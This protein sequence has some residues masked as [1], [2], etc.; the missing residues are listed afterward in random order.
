M[1]SSRTQGKYAFKD[2][3]QGRNKFKS[4]IPQFKGN[5]DVDEFKTQFL[6][7]S[8][9]EFLTDSDFRENLQNRLIEV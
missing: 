5:T 4:N 7:D 3:Q 6:R 9:F 8:D 2:K 1:L